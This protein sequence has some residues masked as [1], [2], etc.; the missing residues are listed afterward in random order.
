MKIKQLYKHFAY[1]GTGTIISILLGFFNTPIITRLVEPSDYGQYSLFLTYSNVIVS[2]IYLG[3]DQAYV[4]YFYNN[5]SKNYKRN[6][7][8]F[9]ILPSISLLLL[10]Y[11]LANISTRY[12]D[13][14]FWT[15][16]L[17]LLL[18]FVNSIITI[19][20]RF[21][22]LVI[23]LNQNSK[24]FA[25][26]GII[27]K[28]FYLILA[29][30]L[31]WNFHYNRSIVLIIAHAASY[32]IV[33]IYCIKKENKLWMLKP[34]LNFNEY[35][36]NYKRIGKYAFPLVFS[37]FVT[38]LF[39]ANDKIFLNIFS[40]YEE[41]GVF[42]SAAS[43]IAIVNAVQTTF[44]TVWAPASIENYTK[45]PD[46]KSFYVQGNKLITI[47]MFMVVLFLILFK[48]IIAILLGESYREAAYILPT[49]A[50]GPLFYTISET[51]VGGIVF[52][53]KSHLNIIVAVLS[54]IVDVLANL[55]LVPALGAKGAA[56]STAISF[57]VFFVLRTYLANREYYVDYKLSRF[58]ILTFIISV[59]A[60]YSTFNSFNYWIIFGFL[61]CFSV[62]VITYRDF[63]KENIRDLI[64]NYFR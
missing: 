64:M 22:S 48:D 18:L 36:L 42:S 62:L 40:T 31:L 34:K 2:F 9:C 15:S 53:E 3:F 57:F 58:Y 44:N 6:L 49:L 41:I 12:F 28:V 61:F 23:R 50:L 1:I 10:L 27:Q 26:L 59:Y 43:L 39:N 7:L 63:I 56:I 32:L 33:T 54:F 29:I 55:L 25:L 14:G 21:S 37:T 45:S 13:L 60:L 35:K 30:S 47:I 11:I 38:T 24:V 19:F 46:N 5:E 4:R 51:T 17:G 20:Y 8:W 52:S 16:T